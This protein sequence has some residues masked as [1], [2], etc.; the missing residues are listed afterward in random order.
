MAQPALPSEVTLREITT[1]N[2]EAVLS[3]DVTDSQRHFVSSNATSIAQAH[4]FNP[5]AWFRGIYAEDE[6]IG[7]MMLHDESLRPEPRQAGYYFLWRLMVDARYQDRGFGRRALELLVDHVRT[8]PAARELL[9]SC[10][11]G[12]GSP[13]AFYLKFGFVPTGR[14]VEGELELRFTLPA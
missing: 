10:H 2:L 14:D 12:D 9:T 1:E 13:E 4:F 8:R 5:E 11:R 3:L 7:F 6:P